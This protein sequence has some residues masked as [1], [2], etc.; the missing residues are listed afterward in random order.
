MLRCEKITSVNGTYGYGIHW[1]YRDGQTCIEF[2]SSMIQ[3]KDEKQKSLVTTIIRHTTAKHPDQL[4][5]SWYLSQC[6]TLCSSFGWEWGIDKQDSFTENKLIFYFLFYFIYS[7][8]YFLKFRIDFEQ[9]GIWNRHFCERWH[10]LN[11]NWI[12][13][14]NDVNSKPFINYHVSRDNCSANYTFIVLPSMDSI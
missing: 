5:L 14:F 11:C 13:H 4:T 1:K 10:I 3:L 6:K 12:E 8:I 9:H 7:F 2:F